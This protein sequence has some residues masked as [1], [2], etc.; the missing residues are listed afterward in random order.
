MTRFYFHASVRFMLNQ[1]N[2]LDFDNNTDYPK[3][4][5]W[6]RALGCVFQDS[7]GFIGVCFSIEN[8]GDVLLVDQKGYE[9]RTNLFNCERISR[10]VK[11][12]HVAEHHSDWRGI[13]H[14]WWVVA[15]PELSTI[16]LPVNTHARAREAA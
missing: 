9:S 10:R 12:I 5:L 13:N 1:N 6:Y 8:G 2:T 16:T 11:T 15:N 7:E 14:K 4:L 3:E